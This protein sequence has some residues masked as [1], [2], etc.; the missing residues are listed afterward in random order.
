MHGLPRVCEIGDHHRSTRAQV[1][2]TSV[3][4]QLIVH[5]EIVCD[6]QLVVR[7]RQLHKRIAIVAVA[8]K[9]AGIQGLVELAVGVEKINVARTVGGE[10][11]AGHPDRTLVPVRRNVEHARLRQGRFVVADDPSGVRANVTMRSPARVDHTIQQEKPGALLILRWLEDDVPAAAV[12]ASPRIARLNLDR[13][14][15]QLRA[16]REIQSMDALVIGRS[17]RRF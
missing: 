9:P 10:S 17:G 15:E 16:L 4:Q 2:I 6:G 3:F 11:G 14:A 8:G 5:L 13:P 7:R 12:V 1:G